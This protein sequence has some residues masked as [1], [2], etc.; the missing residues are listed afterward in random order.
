MTQ[1]IVQKPKAKAVAKAPPPP[2]PL[3][4]TNAMLRMIERVVSNP[5]IDTN[6]IQAMLDMQR[7]LMRDQAERALSAAL[8]E[9][10]I[11]VVKKNG[12]IPLP[13]KDGGATRDVSFAKW[14][15]IYKVLMPVLRAK[16]LSLSF[17]A[18]ARKNDGGGAEMTGRVSHKDGAFREAVISLPLDT[19][20]GRNNL[21]AMG[22]TIAYGKKYLAFMLLNIATEDEDDDGATADSITIEQ[23]ADLHLKLTETGSN[24]KKFLSL[25]G[26]DD[27]RKI[28]QR[29][30]KKAQALI[31]TKKK[32]EKET[33]K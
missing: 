10:D 2:A 17:T 29:D 21:Q 26:V 15:D 31:A 23:A 24:V 18:P 19:G 5:E 33:A 4:E 22:S 7:Q 30:L 13:S 16:N 27:V 25:F 20:P 3:T 8:A 9:I 1:E 6:K 11:P 12:K 32:A 14:P 28:Q